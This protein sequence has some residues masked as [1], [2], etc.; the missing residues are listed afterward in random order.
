MRFCEECAAQQNHPPFARA[1]DD[2]IIYLPTN[3]TILDASSS[4]DLDSNITSYT[5]TK[6]A[7]FAGTA[8]YDAVAFTLGD[9]GYLCT[10]YDGNY[11]NDVWVYDPSTNGW[12]QKASLGG[13]KR[14]ASSEVDARML[15][16]FFSLTMFT[17]R[18]LSRAFSPTIMP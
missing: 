14:I 18:S 6:I 8:R 15:V 4:T 17:S 5:W 7:D 13:T 3:A 16:S 10:G 1:G 11:K 2:Q 9:K 12:T